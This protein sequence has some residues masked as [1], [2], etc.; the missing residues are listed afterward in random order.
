MS[1]QLRGIDRRTFLKVAAA[2]TAAA[3]TP[4]TALAAPAA[5]PAAQTMTY[6]EA[7]ML[8]EMVEAG[9]L[10]AV[11]ERLP[12][13]PRVVPVQEEI[14]EYGGTWRRAYKG[15]SD[16]S[17]Q[18]KLIHTFGLHY[19]S[20]DP[21]TIEIVPGLFDEWT[22]NE[23]STEFTF[24]LREGMRWSDGEFFDTEDIQFWYDWYYQG[25]LGPG[26]SLL[27][28]N[29]TPMELEVVDAYTF[30]V[31]FPEPNPLLPSR[32]ANSAT[33]GSIGGPTFGA[34]AHYLS[35]FIPGTDYTNQ[36]KIDEAL[37]A[38]QLTTWQQLFGDAGNREGP[39]SWW[40][41]NPE[42]P[43]M[44]PWRI[45]VPPPLND[46]IVMVRNPY[47]Y[48][49]DP[50]GQQLPYIDRIDFRLFE[51]NS[52]FDLWITQGLIDMH[53]RH[54]AAANFPLY[55]EHEAS[56]DYRVIIWTQ[57]WTHAYYPNTSHTDPVLRDL[58]TNPKMREAM[59]IA[60]NRDEIN[61]L[62]YDGFYEP[63]QASPVSGSPEFD[64][65][66]EQR[67]TEYDPDRARALLDE[68]GLEVGPDGKR[69]RPDG[70]PLN[71]QLM[72]SKAG[73]Q[74]R[75]DEIDLVAQYWNAIGLGVSIDSVE[76]SL[77][78]ERLANGQV[79]VGHW[80]HDRSL[81]IEG[82]PDSYIGTVSQQP[83][84]NLYAKWYVGNP[85]G[86]EP[87]ADHPIR[88]IW[89]FW[90]QASREADATKRHALVMEMLAVHK[91]APLAIGT[92]GEPPALAITKN[93]FRNVPE[94]MASDTTLRDILL[95]RPEQFFIRQS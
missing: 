70:A 28:I 89:G 31:R 13:S 29:D 16:S 25:D 38:H 47:Y 24:H 42:L 73:D 27:T 50:E 10:P 2:S 54:V 61:N 64:P 72:H 40:F 92:V 57:T 51:D 14:G 17:N 81:I 30:I 93:N 43:V 36:A 5:K 69:L 9:T 44:I 22:Q 75:L 23:D 65:E 8:A 90:E 21:D 55:K 87:P 68:I 32:I 46:P 33:E 45:E 74:P 35:Q 86:V 34:P 6:K 18:I 76:R 19:F 26:Y 4:V 59:S 77:Y 11:D 94:E 83:Y 85:V 79:D 60:I 78:E 39:I 56:G 15:M 12:L 1:H 49:V 20:P 95:A 88:L 63:R 53:Q 41:L 91:E 71:F 84:V 37:A 52:I 58:F 80:E 3:L 48:S 66:F 7:P 67:W 82:N 62:V